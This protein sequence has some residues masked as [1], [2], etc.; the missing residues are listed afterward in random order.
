M[1][2]N[3]KSKRLSISLDK[4][5]AELI[6]EL[7]EKFNSSKAE[8][9]RKSLRYLKVG[10]E[11]GG[12]GLST[13]S[14]Y[15]DFLAKGEHIIIDTEHWRILLGEIG[16]EK[17]KFWKKAKKIGKQHWEIY[18][19]KGFKT[20]EEILEH[21]EKA[22]WYELSKD[23]EKGFTLVLRVQESQE[24]VKVFIESLFKASPHDVDISEGY[25]KL[26]VR[27]PEDK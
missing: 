2:A 19:D 9:I 17:G 4:K 8:V 27:I 10:E 26:R 16:E 25:G 13:I 3:K 20:V 12:V 6:D 18:S 5:S 15:L 11:A 22:N 24:F 23:S 7:Q 21:V 14:A 1:C